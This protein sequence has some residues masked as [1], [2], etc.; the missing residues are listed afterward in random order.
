MRNIVEVHLAGDSTG[1]AQHSGRISDQ[2]FL[3][4][5]VV[6]L[7]SYSRLFSMY[8]QADTFEAYYIYIYDG[9]NPFR[10]LYVRMRTLKL[11]HWRTGS[12]WRALRTGVMCSDLWV[13]DT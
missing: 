6:P 3:V 7:A 1:E 13:F 2:Q 9:A 8:V 10:A 5:H 11:I 12:Q 4:S